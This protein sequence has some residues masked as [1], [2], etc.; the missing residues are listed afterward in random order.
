VD[1]PPPTV[2]EKFFKKILLALGGGQTTPRATVWPWGGFGHP[3]L[4]SM[5]GQNHPQGQTV[6]LGSGLAT[7]RVILK[8][9]NK[10][11]LLLLLLF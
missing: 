4:A 11:V 3:R 2:K 8:N 9:K 10:K 7:P 6:A 5:G 1:Q